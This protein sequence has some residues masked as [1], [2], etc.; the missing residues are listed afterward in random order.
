MLLVGPKMKAMA[1]IGNVC[2][3]TQPQNNYLSRSKIA[4]QTNFTSLGHMPP[5]PPLILP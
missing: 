2:P 3:S 1:H 4:H 5:H